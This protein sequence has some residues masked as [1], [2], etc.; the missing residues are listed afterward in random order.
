MSELERAQSDSERLQPLPPDL[1]VP[2]PDCPLPIYQ[3]NMTCN[4]GMAEAVGT[5]SVEVRWSPVP[6]LSGRFVPL[7]GRGS[8]IDGIDPLQSLGVAVEGG[9]GEVKFRGGRRGHDPYLQFRI[10][11]PFSI[12]AGPGLADHIRFEVVNLPDYYGESIAVGDYGF[13]AG[14]LGLQSKKWTVDL[15]SL[16]DISDRIDAVRESG[17]YTVTHTGRASKRDGSGVTT[18]EAM[19]LLTVLQ[20]TLSVAANRWVTPVRPRGLAADGSVAWEIWG[21]WFTAPW[22]T[23]PSWWDESEVALKDLF[24]GIDD[25]W[26]TKD[27]EHLLRSVVHYYLDSKEGLVNR[28][29]ILGT[30]LLELIGSELVVQR[31]SCTAKKYDG[32]AARKKIGRL[33]DILTTDRGIPGSF[34]ALAEQASRCGWE[35][36]PHAVAEVRNTATHAIRHNEGWRWESH[37]WDEASSLCSHYCD[38]SVLGL[39][40]Y[41]G[42][43]VN[44]TT[45]RSVGDSGPV[46]WATAGLLA[47]ERGEGAPT[48]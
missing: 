30:S 6:Q 22:S 36:G 9:H 19:S 29:L 37:V 48:D 17:G 25:R 28:R 10:Y 44:L 12:Q 32:L 46:P 7:A 4:Q 47:P 23:R 27:W 24:R 15:D 26:A 5:G 16:A 34:K 14:R 18:D 20:Y 41:T 39:L 35:D 31:T 43:Y 42:H 33:L 38:L 8:L 1:V 11:Q 45:A 40:S 3:G 2:D 21:L 13:R